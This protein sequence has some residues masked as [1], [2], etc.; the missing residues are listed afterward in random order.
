MKTILLFA[1]GSFE[2]ATKMPSLDE[3]RAYCQGVETGASFYGAGALGA[4]VM[5]EDLEEMRE[6]ET[7]QAI[8]RARERH[9]DAFPSVVTPG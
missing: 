9:P 4:Y 7:A 1:E 6:R 3:A 5:P 8:E 2:R